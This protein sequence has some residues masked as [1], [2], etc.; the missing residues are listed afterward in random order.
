MNLLDVD[1]TILIETMF[2]LS[3]AIFTLLHFL[4]IMYMINRVIGLENLLSTIRR[5]AIVTFA[6]VHAIILLIL[7]VYICILPQ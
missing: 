3:I 6:L 5:K 4:F 2:K 1:T 7:L